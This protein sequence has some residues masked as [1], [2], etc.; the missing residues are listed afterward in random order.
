MIPLMGPIRQL[1]VAVAMISPFPWVWEYLY[2]LIKIAYGA[3]VNQPLLI[4]E[5]LL[6]ND[7]YIIYV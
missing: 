4:G 5:N 6:N 2:T 3:G 1:P 7:D